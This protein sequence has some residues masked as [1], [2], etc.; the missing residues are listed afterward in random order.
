MSSISKVVLAVLTASFMMAASQ[1]M[2]VSITVKN[3]WAAAQSDTK[4]P[5]AVFM[6]ITDNGD[7]DDTLVSIDTPVAKSAQPHKTKMKG[8]KKRM[9]KTKGLD[10]PAGATVVLEHGAMHVM[11]MGVKQPLVKGESFQLTLTFQ[12]GGAVTVEVPVKMMGM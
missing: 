8:D 6:E 1:A 4:K 5:G 7:Q 9:R 2:A 10:I 3:V 11:L 12:K